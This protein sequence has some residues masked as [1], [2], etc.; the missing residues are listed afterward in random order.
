MR[1]S[2]VVP[3][4][5]HTGQGR[6]KALFLFAERGSLSFR[7]LGKLD[8][9]FVH[10]SAQNE[11]AVQGNNERL[12]FLGD[13]VLGSVVAT[14]LFEALE[15]HPE[16]DLAKAKS[17]LVS[18]DTLSRLALKLGVDALLLLGRGEELSGGRAKKALL[19]D[20]MEAIIGAYYLDSGYGAA[21]AFV[22]A[23]LA[24]DLEAVLSNRSRKDYKTLLQ[25]YCQKRFKT[26]PQYRVIKRTGPDHDRRFWVE[27]QIDGVSYGP[28]VAA[29]KKDA[30]REAAKV[31]FDALDPKDS[32][33]R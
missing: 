7:D 22:K 6:E 30:E 23:I 17:V 28:S 25:E 31:A 24:S 13:A 9:A 4:A 16:G 15:G 19:A 18:E 20:A 29:S 27:V 14:L 5:G 1:E 12:E 3:D 26:Y 33:T 10:R 8:L 11:I 21:F 32:N 2:S